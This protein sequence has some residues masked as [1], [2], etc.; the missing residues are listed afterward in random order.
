MS[1]P[2]SAKQK[3]SGRIPALC[4]HSGSGQC[5][6]RLNGQM[7]YLG[8][9]DDPTT[10]QRYTALLAEWE[11]NGRQAHK[12]KAWIVC[13]SAHDAPPELRRFARGLLEDLPSIQ[14]AL[15]LPWSNGQVQGQINRL[16]LIKRQRYG[17][18]NFDLLRA[19]F[20]HAG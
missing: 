2:K 13:A 9:Y 15:T 16:K 11:A 8:K 4:Y 7:Q 19:R 1:R 14:A 20:L 6:V 18:A 3:R 5:F 17:R 10:R 12:L